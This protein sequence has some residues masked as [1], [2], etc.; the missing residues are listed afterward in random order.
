ML[1]FRLFFFFFQFSNSLPDYLWGIETTKQKALPKTTG[2]YSFQTTYEELKLLP[3][4]AGRS[5]A[6]LRFQTT[7]EEL[8]LAIFALSNALINSC[9][10]TTY[11][12]L[13]HIMGNRGR[14]TFPELPDYLWG[15]ETSLAYPSYGITTDGFQTTYEELKL[16]LFFGTW[17]SNMVCFQTTYEELKRLMFTS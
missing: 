8:K 15:I 5:R 14:G 6:K 13:K 12:E 1:L 10:Q 17:T 2:L 4:R 11:E 9:F 7:Y 16:L 3:Q